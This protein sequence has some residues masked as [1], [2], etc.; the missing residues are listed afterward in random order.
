[1]KIILLK[2]VPGTGKAGTV[3]DVKEGHA[4]NYLIPRGLAVEASAG[5]MRDLEHRKRAVQHRVDREHEEVEAQAQS[6]EGLV[7]E[8]R[9][10][11]GKG[12]RLFGSVTTQQIA[13]ALNRRGFPVT[14]KQIELDK[15]I[16]VEGFYKVP[17]RLRAGVVVHVD[18]NVVGTT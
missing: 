14:R 2:D 3:S 17:I 16:H 18:L 5:A 9:G 6:L 10:K 15:P 11:A 8:I 1:M 12:G 13:E 4:R 7:L